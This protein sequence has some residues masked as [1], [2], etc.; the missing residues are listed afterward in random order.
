MPLTI[1]ELN[2]IYKEVKAFDEFDIARRE[3]HKINS[4]VKIIKIM[5][6]MNLVFIKDDYIFINSNYTCYNTLFNINRREFNELRNQYVSCLYRD[7][8]ERVKVNYNE[9]ITINE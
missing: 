7:Y 2:Y 1:R 6:K 5:T 4:I 9:D 8:K 3:I